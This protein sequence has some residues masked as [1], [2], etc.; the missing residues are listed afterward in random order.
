MKGTA[1]RPSPSHPPEGRPKV[2][3]GIKRARS[4]QRGGRRLVNRL[5]HRNRPKATYRGKLGGRGSQTVLQERNSGRESGQRRAGEQ[6]LF[7]LTRKLG[8]TGLGD[9]KSGDGGETRGWGQSQ[10]RGSG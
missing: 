5:K 8:S 3:K 10:F 6:R 9:V 7:L 4:D 2:P 1:G